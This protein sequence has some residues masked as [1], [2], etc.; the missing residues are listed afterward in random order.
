MSAGAYFDHCTPQQ[1]N[2]MEGVLLHQGCLSAAGFGVP[3]RCEAAPRVSGATSGARARQAAPVAAAAISGLNRSPRINC[4]RLSRCQP[5]RCLATAAMA[6]VATE[7][8]SVSGAM[9]K[10]KEN[11]K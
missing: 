7:W 10:A 8:Q 1:S 6:A 2:Q 4:C 3:V 5:R 11:K 9:A